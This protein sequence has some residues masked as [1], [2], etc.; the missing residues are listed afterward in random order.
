MIVTEELA[1]MM[2]ERWVKTRVHD[3]GMVIDKGL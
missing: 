3:L 2:E 1:V